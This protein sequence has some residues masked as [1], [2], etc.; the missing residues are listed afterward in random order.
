[1]KLLHV[2]LCPDNTEIA[3]SNDYT[4]SVFGFRDWFSGLVFLPSFIHPLCAE[5]RGYLVDPNTVEVHLLDGTK[6]RLRAKN[7]LV[8]VGGM[9]SKIPIEGAVG[10]ASPR[11]LTSC[12]CETVNSI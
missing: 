2:H 10:L 5:G 9:P 1:M 12:A 7:I 6:Q 4:S 11:A 3:K 8:A